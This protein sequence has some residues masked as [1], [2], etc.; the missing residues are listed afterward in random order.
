MDGTLVYSEPLKGKALALACLEFGSSVDYHIYQEVMG[1]D[2]PT[3]TAHF[4]RQ[5]NITPDI[6][7]F[8]QVFRAH[9]Q[10]LLKH[11]LELTLYAQDYLQKLKQEGY[12]LGVVSSAANWMLE[13]ILQQLGLDAFFDII[14]C[15]E[16][17]SQHKPHPEAY[18]V[19]LDKLAIPASEVLVFED[20]SAGIRAAS[21]AGCD[22]IAIQHEFNIK[23]NLEGSL[24]SIRHFNEMH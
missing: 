10:D 13:Q 16:D 2:W 11:E 22:V 15:Q 9:Y 7:N 6:D 18:L 4:F 1:E 23:N 3:V 8:N 21:A 19:A 5:A 20:S 17:V 12:K 14:I 24:T